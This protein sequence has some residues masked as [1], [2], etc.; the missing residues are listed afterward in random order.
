MLGF[1][2]NVNDCKMHVSFVTTHTS[3][4]QGYFFLHLFNT[5][6]ITDEA[7]VLII[8]NPVTKKSCVSARF[9][10]TQKQR[11]VVFSINLHGNIQESKE[12]KE[13]KGQT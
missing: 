5:S 10:T 11:F 1:I 4:L 6:S 13:K 2:E 3:Y 7:G 9:K 8:V 12:G